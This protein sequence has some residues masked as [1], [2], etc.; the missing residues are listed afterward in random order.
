MREGRSARVL[1]WGS[2][3]ALV[4]LLVWADSA[5][6]DE[7]TRAN[8]QVITSSRNQVIQV[9]EGGV[10]AE[11]L[12]AEGTQVKRGQLLARLD[13]TKAETDYLE[14]AAKAAALLAA[15][16][17]LTAEVY[18]GQPVFPPEIA[19]Y[20]DFKANQLA[21]FR[22][23]QSAM[24]EEIGAIE[25]Q[26]VL[27][28]EELDINKRLYQTGDVARSEVLKL[29]RQLVDIQ[30]QITNR[31]NKY[32]QDSQAE[33]V[34]TQ[35]DLAGVQQVVAQR[36]SQL[37]F[38]E[39]RS[40]MDGVVR[41]VRI[42]TLGAV[43]RTGEELMQI[44]PVDDDL[45]IEA[46][47]RAAD[48]AFIRVGLPVTIKMDAYDYTIYGLLHGEVIFISADTLVDELHPNEP[49]YYRV[50][51]RSHAPDPGSQIVAQPG[52]TAGIEILTGKKTVLAYLTKPIT[53]TLTESLGE[54]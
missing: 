25:K 54:R 14:G 9:P 32:L 34:K 45:V 26:K 39:V 53:K 44:V 21:L 3:L 49:P 13:R 23:R 43:A 42:T 2:A 17:R 10:L 50:H 12:V 16:A 30:S 46:K 47:V 4:T 52:M 31:R 5:E 35:E 41:N 48:I 40:P 38:T 18:G 15:A 29:E 33:L 8:G 36:K 22:R 51:V 37:G 20:P 6:L 19:D 1:I 28:Q 7:I 24:N 27:T 11:M